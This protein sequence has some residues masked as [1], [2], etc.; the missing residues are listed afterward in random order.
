LLA[1]LVWALDFS[2][3]N[4]PGL[5]QGS[6]IW[7]FVVVL[8]CAFFAAFL[9]AI[10]SKPP[11][12]SAHIDVKGGEDATGELL[13]SHREFLVYLRTSGEYIEKYTPRYP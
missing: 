5:L 6:S 11:L 13:A 10:P 2:V 3:D 7:A 8:V 4:L 12:S 1:L 9:L